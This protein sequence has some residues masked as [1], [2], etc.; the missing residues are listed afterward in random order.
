[1]IPFPRTR[2]KRPRKLRRTI[3]IRA[4]N[5][6]RCITRM[7][8]VFKCR[9]LLIRITIN[10]R[11]NNRRVIKGNIR[12]NTI[13][14]TKRIRI[15]ETYTNCSIH[16]LR[17]TLLNSSKTTRD[18]NRIVC[19]RC[20]LYQVPIRLPLRNRRSKNYRLQII[21]SNSA[22]MNVQFPRKGIKRRQNVRTNIVLQANMSSTMKSILS[23]LSNNISNTTSKN[24]F[25]RIKTYTQCSY[26]SRYHD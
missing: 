21:I 4:S 3:T 7:I 11:T 15:R 23:Y 12:S 8:S 5:I 16:R 1:M 17:S 18:N 24:C 6:G 22:R 10:R 25:R 2:T 20:S 19:R 13:R 14:L 9:T 26:C